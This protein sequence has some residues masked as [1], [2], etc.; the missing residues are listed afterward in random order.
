MKVRINITLSEEAVIALKEVDNVSQHIEDLILGNP[1]A[2]VLE[3]VS[4]D[5]VKE[6]LKAVVKPLYEKNTSFAPQNNQIDDVPGEPVVLKMMC[7]VEKTPCKHWLWNG[8]KGGWVNSITGE[9]R[10]VL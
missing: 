6:L 8:D 1:T 7:C 2:K 4:V 9:L 10:E 3:V 5:V